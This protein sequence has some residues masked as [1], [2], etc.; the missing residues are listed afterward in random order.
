MW[1]FHN[2]SALCGEISENVGLLPTCFMHKQVT[3]K[4]YCIAGIIGEPCIWQ[5]AILVGFQ[6]GDLCTVCKETHAFSLN[7]MHLIYKIHQTVKL[8]WSTNIL[9]IQYPL[10]IATFISD[11]CS[12]H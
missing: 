11:W 8:E 7:V 2:F 12:R 10:E 3:T 9:A 1:S 4:I 5:F 6:I